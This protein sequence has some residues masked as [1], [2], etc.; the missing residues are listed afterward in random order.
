MTLSQDDIQ[1]CPG[2]YTFTAYH[3]QDSSN[4]CSVKW[5]IGDTLVVTGQP[6]KT[7]AALSATWS[8]AP[9]LTK[10]NLKA[11]FTCAKGGTSNRVLTDLV[12]LVMQ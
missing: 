7:W 9:G 3:L 4:N 8:P 2:K 5:Y 11:V 10:V 6:G 12:T 1:I